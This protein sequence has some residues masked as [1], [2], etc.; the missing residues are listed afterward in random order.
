MD[1]ITPFYEVQLYFVDA[2]GTAHR[3]TWKVARDEADQS[4]LGT[5]AYLQLGLHQMWDQLQDDE[6]ERLL[7]LKFVPVEKGRELMVIN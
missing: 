6:D 3:T 2:D 5:S 7:T 1:K 4:T